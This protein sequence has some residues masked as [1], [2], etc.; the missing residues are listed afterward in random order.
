MFTCIMNS[1]L[2]IYSFTYDEDLYILP[3]V[4]YRICNGKKSAY[5]RI[6]IRFVF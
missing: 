3:T 5:L 6:F 1:L 2:N 4:P